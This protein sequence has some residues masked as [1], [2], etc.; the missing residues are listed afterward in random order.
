MKVLAI[1]VVAWILTAVLV[2]WE[3]KNA[4]TMP[5]DYDQ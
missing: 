5:E 4:P 2:W 3:A 1:I